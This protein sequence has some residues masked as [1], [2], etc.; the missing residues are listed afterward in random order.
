M[1]GRGKCDYVWR[2]G[3]DV[4]GGEGG[5]DVTVY[6]GERCVYGGEGGDVTVY[7]GEGERCVYGGEGEM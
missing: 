4:Y 6:G 2:E 7:G 1:E 5:R 3:G